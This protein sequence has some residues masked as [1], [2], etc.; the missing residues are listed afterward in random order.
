MKH[1][2]SLKYYIN[3]PSYINLINTRWYYN[4]QSAWEKYNET[5]L[6][7][8]GT[9]WRRNRL[10]SKTA[11]KRPVKHKLII[12]YWLIRWVCGNMTRWTAEIKFTSK[13]GRAE[14][15]WKAHK[16][17]SKI[18]LCSGENSVKIPLSPIT[19]LI[20]GDASCRCQIIYAIRGRQSQNR[21]LSTCSGNTRDGEDNTT[22][23]TGWRIES[24]IEL[25]LR[26]LCINDAV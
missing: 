13:V 10:P 22:H 4:R 19:S 6:I 24:I 16:L 9:R 2:V 17:S 25:N 21:H 1:T 3:I 12:P 15:P 14:N 26:H 20:D 5:N 11:D 23:S 18:W 7:S 8:S